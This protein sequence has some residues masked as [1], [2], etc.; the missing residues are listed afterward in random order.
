[1]SCPPPRG[2]LDANS[3]IPCQW[4]DQY[5]LWMRT[6]GPRNY[7]VTAFGSCVKWSIIHLSISLS[8]QP[9]MHIMT[10]HV[11]Y[12][13]NI[14]FGWE[15]GP[16]QLHDHGLWLVCWND[17]YTSLYLFK[18]LAIYADSDKPCQL[19]NQYN[20]WMKTKNPHNYMVT[21]FGS[22]VEMTI[23]HPSISLC[24]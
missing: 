5:N 8:F 3:S 15:Q 10:H 23:I 16:S 17:H 19:H 20:L 6:M 24:F 13:T 22:Y 7:M 2:R 14:T 1:M 12:T 11:N 4:Q 9:C 21:T 18:I